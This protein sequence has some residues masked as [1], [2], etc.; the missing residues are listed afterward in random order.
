MVQESD[1]LWEP[2]EAFKRDANITQFM[3]WL[4]QRHGL[5][6]KDY[7]ALWAWSVADIE[8]F[9]QCIWDYF[10]VESS[11]PHQCVLKNRDMPGATWFPGAR[12]N[13]GRHLLSKARAGEV[14]FHH[15]SEIRPRAYTT[16]DEVVDRTQKLATRMRALGVKPGDRVVSFMPAIAET[17]IAFYA[18]VSIG[19]V[20]SCCSPDFG[21]SSVVDRFSQIDP[22]LIFA[23]DGYRYGA[24][25]FDRRDEVKAL[26]DALPTIEHV[27]TVPY[28]FADQSFAPVA[29]TLDWNTIQTEEPSIAPGDFQFEDVAFDHPLWIVYS[30]GT[31]GLPKPFVHGHGGILL[32]VLKYS[33]FHINL[34][35]TSVTFLFSTT[36]WVV[37]NIVACCLITGSAAVFY[38]GNP[39]HPDVDVLWRMCAETRTTFFGTSPTFVSLMMANGV[40]PKDRYDLS[41]LEGVFCTGS[42]ATPEQF[43]WFYENV[44]QDLWLTS[45]SGGTDVASG[46]VC[47]VPIMPVYAGEI[48]TRALGVDVHVYDDNGN[49]VIDQLGELVVRQAMPSMPLYFWKDEGNK[50]YIESYFETFPGSWRHG[51]YLMI[52]SRGGCFVRG[53][54]DSTLNRYGVRMGTAEIYRTVEALDEIRDSIIVNLD[55][56]DGRFFMPLFVTMGPGHE[57]SDGLKDRICQALRSY[58]PRH[59]PDK[60]YAIDAIPYTLTGKKMEVPV[61]KILMGTPPE[62]AANRDTMANPDSIDYFV[63]FAREHKDYELG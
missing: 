45:Q 13:F 25:D 9:W 40:V 8:F 10:E 48:Q 54:S 55:L 11:T 57:M 17:A 60:I 3:T 59:V 47:G 62:K 33:T 6:F 36:G 16:W 37:W 18:T 7:D 22:V 26:I 29:G 41:S 49:I 58:S 5:A 28:L 15:L 1:L 63:E 42:P 19:A 61:R 51:D 12:V 2:G 43:A 21:H 20:W 14:A 31:T 35:P 30:S 39:A 23:A 53:R 32:E 4:S 38:D 46:F 52:T 27:V 24:R 56:P 34:K 50:R 44:R